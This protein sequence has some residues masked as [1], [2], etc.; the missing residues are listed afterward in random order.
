MVD[1]IVWFFEKASTNV[2][3]TEKT[4]PFR[5]FGRKEKEG[6]MMETTSRQT[7]FVHKLTGNTKN[8]SKTTCR[9]LFF[10]FGGGG[11]GAKR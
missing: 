3:N 7:F 1:V 6:N 10:F 2:E 4:E 5:L 8:T 9:F 11:G